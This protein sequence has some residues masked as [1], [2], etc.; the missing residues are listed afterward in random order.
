MLVTLEE[1]LYT[2]INYY[3]GSAISPCTTSSCGGGGQSA[4]GPEPPDHF[5]T[6]YGY[7]EG[8]HLDFRAVVLSIGILHAIPQIKQNK[9][10]AGTAVSAHLGTAWSSIVVFLTG[11]R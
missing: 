7:W 6:C 3:I 8:V 1:I 2:G 11:P 5:E 4:A 10:H 9:L